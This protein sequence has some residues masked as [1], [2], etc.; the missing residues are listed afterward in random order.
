MIEIKEINK[1]DAY[2]VII[3][4]P[5]DIVYNRS[6][7]YYRFAKGQW[8]NHN[9]DGEIEYIAKYKELEDEFQEMHGVIHE[10]LLLL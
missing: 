2:R 1:L 4:G 3:N 7:I 6:N 8:Y 5:E 10:Q 9:R